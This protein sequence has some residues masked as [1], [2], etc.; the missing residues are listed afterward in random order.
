MQEDVEIFLIDYMSMSQVDADRILDQYGLN[1]E[2]VELA[3]SSKYIFPA[4]MPTG[5]LKGRLESSDSEK[6]VDPFQNSKRGNHSSDSEGEDE[7]V[8]IP[9]Q[10]RGKVKKKQD[11]VI[12]DKEKPQ[13]DDHKAG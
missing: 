5:K 9:D 1:K 6:E 7:D 2:D 3:G 4:E 13:N 12:H 11:D 10:S 8:P